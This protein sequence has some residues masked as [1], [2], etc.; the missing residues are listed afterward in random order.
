MIPSSTYIAVG[1]YLMKKSREHD[2]NHIYKTECKIQT[3]TDDHSYG[4]VL[5]DML[6]DFGADMFIDFFM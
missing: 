2:L 1:Q 5:Y 6:R 4:S 3:E